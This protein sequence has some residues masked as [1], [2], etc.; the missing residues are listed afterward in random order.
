MEKIG[1]QQIWSYFDDAEKARPVS[2]RRI[3]TG[4]GHTV[5]TFFELAMKVAELQFLNRNHVMLF[6]GQT[7]DHM[8]PTG[9]MLNPTLF[10]LSGKRSA[11]QRILQAR[12]ERLKAAEAHLVRLYRAAN[13]RGIDRLV[14]H[15]TIRWSIL[16]HYDVCRTPLL[17][18][19]QSLRIAA[20]FAARKNGSGDAYLYVLGVPNRSGAV[21]ASSESGLQII[22]LSSAC[23]PEAVRPHM[24]EGFLL[25]EYPEIAD[26]DPNGRHAYQEMDFGRRLVAKFKLNLEAFWNSRDF[27]PASVES[28]YPKEFDPLLLVADQIK[29]EIGPEIEA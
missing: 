8:S 29:R 2:N 3:R 10:R 1:P 17:D 19:S 26:Y 16:Q 6:R 20:S 24:Q 11:I 13:L 12:F 4:E 27:P 21:T 22:C 14:R 9:T 18:L 28:I 23:P 7:N 15:R 5:F 25:G